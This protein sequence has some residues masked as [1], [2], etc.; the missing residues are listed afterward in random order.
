[1]MAAEAAK[2]TEATEA[3]R[4]TKD[5]PVVPS[6]S[7]SDSPSMID[8]VAVYA[9]TTEDIPLVG[10]E[11]G[12]RRL[13]RVL[14]PAAAPPYV[15]NPVVINRESATTYD[16]QRLSLAAVDEHWV[17]CEGQQWLVEGPKL[18][19]FIQQLVIDV[20]KVLG[21][22]IYMFRD[23]P[24]GVARS[25]MLKAE[26]QALKTLSS[27]QQRFLKYESSRAVMAVHGDTFLSELKDIVEDARAELKKRKE[28]LND[29][30]E[31]LQSAEERLQDAKSASS[32]QVYK[33]DV[34]SSRNG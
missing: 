21:S 16:I 34:S 22:S 1:M 20:R 25:Y 7:P 5:A 18:E 9:Q 14:E 23:Y 2:A 12:E 8:V 13:I 3:S 26:V 30:E 33:V 19:V 28:A 31:A 27:S 24:W 10:R 4:V 15:D 17:V 6:D 29:A 11:V 32:K